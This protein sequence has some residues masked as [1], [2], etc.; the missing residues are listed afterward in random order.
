MVII[1]FKAV[2][3]IYRVS[4]C[5]YKQDKSLE[6]SCTS[7]EVSQNT[8]LFTPCVFVSVLCIQNFEQMWFLSMNE[9]C[10][11]DFPSLSLFLHKISAKRGLI[12]YNVKQNII[13]MI[14]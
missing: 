13:H 9:G 7:I 10:V 1:P 3:L 14:I 11:N 12:L 8:L 2:H 6:P 5:C 4:N